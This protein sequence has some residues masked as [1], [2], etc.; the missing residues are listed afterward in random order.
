M[1]EQEGT[2]KV[3]MSLRT[4]CSQECQ[5]LSEV[6][7]ISPSQEMQTGERRKCTVD[8]LMTNKHYKSDVE[9]LLHEM[10]W[11]MAEVQKPVV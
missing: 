11:L 7:N 6:Y 4:F 3:Q 2:A 5:R 9:N 1:S 10:C 8:M